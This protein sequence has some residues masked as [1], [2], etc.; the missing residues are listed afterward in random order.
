MKQV[1]PDIIQWAIDWN[2]FDADSL[3]KEF[4][5]IRQWLDGTHAP[6]FKQLERFAAKTHTIVPYFFMQS[7]PDVRLQIADFRRV[8]Q[9][10]DILPSPEL[11]ETIDELLYKQAWLR[12]FFIEEDVERLPWIGVFADQ[13]PYPDVEEVAAYLHTL[14]GLSDDWAS[15]EMVSSVDD[16]WRKLRETIEQQRVAVF[17]SGYAGKNTRRS[18][19]VDE[20]RGFAISDEYA[21][22]V[23]VN[24]TD[25]KTAQIFT[26][27]HEM[28][29][30]LFHQTGVSGPF[31]VE[32]SESETE[33]YCDQV[34]AEFLLPKNV[35]T[36][37][38]AGFDDNDNA[39]NESQKK[40]R[41]SAIV[42]LRRAR[43]LGLIHQQEFWTLY[44]K[45]CSYS[46]TVDQ[47]RASGGNY[48][49]T[50]G[51][52]LGGVFAD[53]VYAALKTGKLQFSEAYTMTGMK[54]ENLDRFYREKGLSL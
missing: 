42:V 30:L 52:K 5:K 1:N 23:F 32:G 48:Y 24:G 43:D 35:F 11:F 14:L 25:A 50:Q 4:P 18:F 29:H 40:Y 44:D 6:T 53:A 45:H 9:T 36:G 47:N 22:A 49:R 2:G 34:A 28:A 38:W 7:I 39:V 46:S 37:F 3:V 19:K 13:S 27:V 51:T 20:F 33:V 8:S 54:S 31:D 12:D 26:L 21:P 10:D 15:E 17:I 16:A 41:V